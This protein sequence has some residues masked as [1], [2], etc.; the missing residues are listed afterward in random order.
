LLSVAGGSTLKRLGPV[1]GLVVVIVVVLARRRAVRARKDA[2]RLSR[3][4]ASLPSV[5]ELT[6]HL[7]DVRVPDLRAAVRRYRR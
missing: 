7:P 1:V 2:R 4:A 6:E 5:G 3:L